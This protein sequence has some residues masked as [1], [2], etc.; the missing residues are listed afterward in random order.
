[1]KNYLYCLLIAVFLL[2]SCDKDDLN[3]APTKA[4]NIEVKLISDFDVLISWDSS[5]DPDG[6]TVYYFIEVNGNLLEAKTENNEITMDIE[7]FLP[8]NRIKEIRGVYVGLDI[9]IKAFDSNDLEA[10]PL[11]VYREIRVNR[12][13][14]EFDIT[15]IEL[16]FDTYK[17]IGINWS[18]ADDKDGDIIK[19]DIYLNS[20]LL[21]EN[22]IISG[23]ETY[24]EAVIAYDFFNLLNIPL[25]FKI[26]ANDNDGGKSES[27][28]T[29][30]LRNTDVN[31][32]DLSPFYSENIS[33]TITEDEIDNRIGLKFNLTENSGFSV[34][35]LLTNDD[36]KF[37]LRDENG[38]IF[39]EG[40]NV[41]SST[42]ISEGNYYLEVIKDI[43][44][45]IEINLTLRDETSSDRDLGVITIP[46]DETFNIEDLNSEPDEKLS[47]RFEIVDENVKFKFIMNDSTSELNLGL[48]DENGN[49]I[50]DNYFNLEGT[51]TEKGIYYLNL[52]KANNAEETGRL[53]IIF[54][55]I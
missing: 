45:T 20:I 55:E 5:V 29:I 36:V 30:S 4:A 11:K 26:I 41:I 34:S 7:E 1:M 51:I 3:A 54:E 2:L 50:M 24:G 22:I 10:E 31:L 16:N 14:L 32:G 38:N 46:Y 23:G 18:L 25:N 28:K 44:S 19:Y 35:D 6:D 37:I 48:V 12:N 27:I 9:V 17:E 43:E 39:L 42:N 49:Y 13:P 47:F 21:K 40:T 53:N 33:L 8:S 15:D 52:S